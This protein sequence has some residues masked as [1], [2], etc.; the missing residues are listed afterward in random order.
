MSIPVEWQG[1]CTVREMAERAVARG[2]IPRNFDYAL[3]QK[4]VDAVHA[5][6]GVWPQELGMVWGYPDSGPGHVWG[7]PYGLTSEARALL[8]RPEVAALY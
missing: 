4:W 5:A 2:D 1:G 6:T 3:P 8:E 7:R